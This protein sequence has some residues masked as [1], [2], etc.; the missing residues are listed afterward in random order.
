MGDLPLSP[1]YFFNH[2]CQYKLTNIYLFYI[3]GFNPKLLYFIAQIVPALAIGSAFSWQDWNLK[4]G[5]CRMRM[6]MR[7]R[8]YLQRSGN[9][10]WCHLWDTCEKSLLSNDCLLPKRRPLNTHTA[11][12]TMENTGCFTKMH[13]KNDLEG[14]LYEHVVMTWSGCKYAKY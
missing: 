11:I 7:M 5:L 9:R 1:I 6:R 13:V 10:N 14:K 3:M 12:W 4:G 8:R 2:L